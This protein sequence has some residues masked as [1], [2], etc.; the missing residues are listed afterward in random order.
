[1]QTL[2]IYVY[3]QYISSKIILQNIVLIKQQIKHRWLKQGSSYLKS[4]SL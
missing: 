2:Q 4:T 1:M 3:R